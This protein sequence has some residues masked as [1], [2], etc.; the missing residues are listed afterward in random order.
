MKRIIFCLMFLALI[1]PQAYAKK[2]NGNGGGG[3]GPDEGGPHL[4]LSTDPNNFDQGG[5]GYVGSSSDDWISESYVTYNNPFKMYLY[6]AILGNSPKDAI[7]AINIGLLVAVHSGEQGEV[8][9]KDKDGN[10]TTI[11]SFILTDINPYYG[12]GYHGVYQNPNNPNDPEAGDAVFAVY[13]P[14][15]QI[16]LS[17]GEHTEFNITFS[18]FSQAHF[19]AF[20]ENGYWNPPSHDVTATPEPTSLALLG[21]G[22]LGLFGIRKKKT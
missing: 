9:I 6:K 5:A 8:V 1:L 2:D 18:G 13:H 3:G 14:S 22:L 20:S 10:I 19:D 11:S 15:P 16:D 12:G 21:L 7:D 17:S 4:W